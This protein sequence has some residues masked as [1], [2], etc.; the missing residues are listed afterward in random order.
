MSKPLPMC[1][2][3]CDQ[4]FPEAIQAPTGSRVISITKAFLSLRK[5]QGF[6]KLRQEAGGKDQIY[7]L[8][9]YNP[10][11]SYTVISLNRLK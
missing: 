9:Y 4:P 11:L 5:F 1:F 2:I 8:L 3:S 10:E 6:L 7:S